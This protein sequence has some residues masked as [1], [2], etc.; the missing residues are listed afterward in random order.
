MGRVRIGINTGEVVEED[1]DLF[2]KAVNAAATV[3]AQGEG[4]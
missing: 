4:G 3:A 2:G 1:E